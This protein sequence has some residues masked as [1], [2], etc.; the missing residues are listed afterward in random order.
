[1]SLAAGTELGDYRILAR[2]GTGAYGEVYEAEH[3]ITRRRDAIKVLTHDRLHSAEEEQRFLQEIQVQA[4]LH[5]PNIAAVYGAFS[6]PHGLALVMEFIPGEPLSAILVRDR[7]PIERGIDLVL[8]VLAALSYAHAEGVVHRDIK[9]ENVIVT[10]EG[11]VKLTDFGLARSATSPRLTQ[12]G[13]FAGSPFYMSPEQARGTQAADSRSDTY[14]AGVVLYEVVTGQLPFAGDSTIEVLLAHQYSSPR[15]PEE[16]EPA[17]GPALS[18][19]IL[20]AIEKDPDRRY[21]TASAFFAALQDAAPLTVAAPEAAPG[22]NV[23]KYRIALA[24]GCACAILAA[25]SFASVGLERRTARQAVERERA[26]DTSKDTSKA[27]AEVVQPVF[28]PDTREPESD[29]ASPFVLADTRSVPDSNL[30]PAPPPRPPV[31]ARKVVQSIPTD[32]QITG[33][34]PEAPSAPAHLSAARLPELPHSESA[35]SNVLD[36]PVART[37]IIAVAQLEETSPTTGTDDTAKE[38]SAKRRNVVVRVVQKVFHSHP[39]GSSEPSVQSA[40][41]AQASS[42][43]QHAALTTAKQPQQ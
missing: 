43:E 11:S 4:S 5:H 30:P 38:P 2:I 31:R 6:T 19:V 23:W 41:P 12:S 16:L 26:K 33:S 39:K 7:I 9:P 3:A 21:Q 40:N 15:P 14:S 22:V 35:P 32:L 34:V 37:P 20:T 17:V 27:T 29:R 1:M 42:A 18:Q 13:S 25:A 8:D 28:V 10:P 24:T 36:L